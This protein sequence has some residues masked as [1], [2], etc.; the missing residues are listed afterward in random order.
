MANLLRQMPITYEPLR[1]NRFT[2]TFP[3]EIGLAQWEVQTAGFP[4]YTSNAVEI[5]YLNTKTFVV[6]NFYWESITIKFIDNIGPSTGVKIMEWV[7]LHSES[8][9]GRQ[10]YAAGYKKDILMDML[11]P[12]GVAV[13]RWLLQDCMIVSAEFGDG[14]YDDDGLAMPSLVIQPD[15]CIRQY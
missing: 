15:R 12:T 7:R 1:N 9:S 5:P 4:K 14:A 3:E 8:I 10:G 13:S 6:G 2:V 11:D